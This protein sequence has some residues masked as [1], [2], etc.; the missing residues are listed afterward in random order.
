MKLKT[1]KSVALEFSSALGGSVGG[2]QQCAHLQGLNVSGWLPPLTGSGCLRMASSR[3]LFSLPCR[4][5]HLH[6]GF[7]M[8]IQELAG[9]AITVSSDVL[10]ST[11]LFRPRNTWSGLGSHLLCREADGLCLSTNQMH[12]V[13]R[14]IRSQE[15]LEVGALL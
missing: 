4:A 14:S 5:S 13:S 1:S 10:A 9:A 15:T 11:L 7:S 3:A 8:V 6:P 12:Y 2:G